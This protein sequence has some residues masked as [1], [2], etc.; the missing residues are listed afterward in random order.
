M[1]DKKTLPKQVHRLVKDK[2]PEEVVR[3]MMA[4]V[5]VEGGQRK[6]A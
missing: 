1:T 5:E 6:P 3:R 2:T 4:S